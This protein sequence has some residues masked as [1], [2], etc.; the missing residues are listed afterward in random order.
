MPTELSIGKNQWKVWHF[1]G[2][3]TATHNL[4]NGAKKKK[5]STIKSLREYTLRK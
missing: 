3:W 2:F 4:P 5:F 1:G